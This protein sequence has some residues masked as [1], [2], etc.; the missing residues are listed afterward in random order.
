MEDHEVIAYLAASA[1]KH[2]RTSLSGSQGLSHN[3]TD[4]RKFLNGHPGPQQHPQ[5]HPQQYQQYPPH[6][7]QQPQYAPQYNPN[8]IPVDYV[9]PEG[10]LPPSNTRLLSM[11]PGFIDPNS[12]ANP[13]HNQFPNELRTT[14]EEV[15][16]FQVPSYDK[17]YLEDEQEFRDA[18]IKEIK[19]Q[20]TIIKKLNK[21]MDALKVSLQTLTDMVQS[22]TTIH[23]H[24]PIS[25]DTI[26]ENPIES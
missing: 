16:N 22:L 3:R 6:P 5:Q 2:M 1:E 26:D 13:V 21:D 18:L 23:I 7:Q 11:P 19:S 8:N 15:N 17:K 9:I 10:T 14:F 20:K 25:K 4:F 24:P 12:A